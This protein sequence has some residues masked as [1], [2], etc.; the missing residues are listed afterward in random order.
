[1]LAFADVTC[2]PFSSPIVTG[3]SVLA[4]KYKDGIMMMS[5]TLGLFSFV[6]QTRVS[7]CFACAASYGSLACYTEV[8]RVVEINKYT[9]LGAS[10]LCYLVSLHLRNVSH[11]SSFEGEFS[12]FQF[13]Q[14]F[15]G[16]E[17]LLMFYTI[18]LLRYYRF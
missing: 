14:K 9:M 11:V 5:D 7:F 15:L 13:I 3:A 4:I 2:Y 8:N 6:K 10:G 16:G 18:E 12:D 17:L 1:L